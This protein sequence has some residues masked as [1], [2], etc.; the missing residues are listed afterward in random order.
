[1]IKPLIPAIPSKTVSIEGKEYQVYD[2]ISVRQLMNRN[3]PY[4]LVRVCINN[5]TKRKVVRT[6]PKI[7]DPAKRARAIHLYIEDILTYLNDYVED[8]YVGDRHQYASM[9]GK[10]A[11]SRE[12]NRG[13]E[14]T[15]VK[16][17]VR[18]GIGEK[19]RFVTKFIGQSAKITQSDIDARVNE[20]VEHRRI[21]NT[22]YNEKLAAKHK[23]FRD[24]VEQ[25]IAIRDAEFV[26]VPLSA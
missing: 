15:S 23:A 20:A 14:Y 5:T 8:N 11:I 10:Y 22:Q 3:N 9:E 26:G 2:I 1:M 16:Y 25:Q 13:C 19:Q 12:K 18:A 7:K 6:F 17:L 4:T 24:I 21:V